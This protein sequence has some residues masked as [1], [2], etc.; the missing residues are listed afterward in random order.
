MQSTSITRG[1]RKIRLG[2][3]DADSVDL[4]V[5]RHPG[6]RQRGT[7]TDAARCG[8]K[9]DG[10]MMM[11]HD[12]H[13]QLSHG[14]RTPLTSVLGYTQ[15]MMDRWDDLDELQRLEFV[16]IVYGEALRMAHSV[17]QVDRQLYRKLAER[18]ER[19]ERFKRQAML[20]DAS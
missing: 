9:G 2:L 17:E 5:C 11:E 13:E 6:A 3:S 16:R 1:K 4:C 7:V 20:A 14:L 12:L 8:R 15:T 19:S 18:E 10:R